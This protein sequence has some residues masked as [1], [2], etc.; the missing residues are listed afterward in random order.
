MNIKLI[1]I[2]LAKSVFQICAVNRAGKVLFNR[3]IRR[4]R[5]RATMAQF[6]PTQ[7]ATEACGSAHYWGRTFEQLGHRVTLIP[8][9]HVKPFVRSGK[10]DPHDALA[11]CEAANRPNLHPVPIKSLAQQD[12]QV[13]HRIRQRHIQQATALANQIRSIGREYG[14]V[15][16]KGITTLLARL[17]AALEDG[18]NELSMV[19]RG[20]LHDHFLQLQAARQAAAQWK[21]KI[22]QLASQ[23]PAFDALL[24][25]PG[26]GPI[27][28]AAYLVAIGDGR[29]FKNG[30]QVSAWLGLT[31]RQYGSGGKL[32][33]RGITKQGDRY[34]RQMLIH[35][36]R[37]A[38][39]RHRPNCP[40]LAT[41]VDPIIARR[42][43]NKAVVA[44]ANKLARIAWTLV[45]TRSA[46][47]LQ[48][49]F[50][51]AR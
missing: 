21:Q 14:L 2:D 42:G 9:Q 27:T 34:T 19:A 1:G 32:T 5:V 16:P 48:Q 10:S 8:P 11:I 39:C 15:F 29:Q 43:F 41:W 20:A 22:I 6:E 36:A 24:Q 30:R 31:P 28:A 47:D 3:S 12:L 38:M 17:P 44:L 23:L 18:G 7:V 46:F 49:A 51:P 25:V 50:K 45:R 33:L 26:F 4:A 35:G 37:A 40:P 13:L